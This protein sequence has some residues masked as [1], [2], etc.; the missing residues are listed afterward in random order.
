MLEKLLIGFDP[1]YQYSDD[2]RNYE[3]GRKKE[4]EIRNSLRNEPELL[5][6][7]NQIT[8]V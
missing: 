7:F 6:Q 5:R 1:Y 2:F 4:N 3:E 8:N